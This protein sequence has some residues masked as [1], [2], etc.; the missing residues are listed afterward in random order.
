MIIGQE[1][2]F[3]HLACEFVCWYVNM[4]A[5]HSVLRSPPSKYMHSI[6]AISPGSRVSMLREEKDGEWKNRGAK[7]FCDDG[8]H[9]IFG[10][11]G[12]VCFVTRCIWL[13]LKGMGLKE[14]CLYVTVCAPLIINITLCLTMIQ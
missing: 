14:V 5:F 6:P 2:G 4:Y 12:E 9:D 8:L 3:V 1:D 13:W 11:C 10:P 7:K